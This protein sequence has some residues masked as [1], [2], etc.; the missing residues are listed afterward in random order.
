MG[1]FWDI[2]DISSKLDIVNCKVVNISKKFMT[3]FVIFLLG[4]MSD[5]DLRLVPCEFEILMRNCWEFDWHFV[6]SKIKI[7][8]IDGAELLQYFTTKRWRLN[9]RKLQRR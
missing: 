3:K 8:G 6:L 7:E 1:L 2:E 9:R 4:L 5:W